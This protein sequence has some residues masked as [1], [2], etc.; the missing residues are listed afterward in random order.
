MAETM[1]K[2][3]RH[4]MIG[5]GLMMGMMPGAA[6]AQAVDVAPAQ[7][8]FDTPS[9]AADSLVIAIARQDAGALEAILGSA[10]R[11]L[12]PP[13][14]ISAKNKDHFFRAWSN[15][16]TLIPNGKA[17]RLLLV[18]ESAWTLP[19][20]IVRGAQG[21]YFDTATAGEWIRV[22][23]IGRNELA[24]MRAMLAYRDA[25]LEY[26][27]R[28][29]DGDGKLE[30]A[31]AFISSPGHRNG[32]YWETSSSEPNCPL[33]PRFAAKT[34]GAAYH[35]YYYRI[36]TAQGDHAPGGAHSY[37]EDG[38]MVSGFALI[39]WPADYGNS[40]IMSFMI[41]RDGRLYETDLGPDG[42]AIATALGAF[43]PG[44]RW[45]PVAQEY[46]R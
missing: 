2:A 5:S 6:V 42:E 17:S 11:R 34:P 25:Q 15:F 16:H 21:W 19:I 41:S 39:A 4:I 29:H 32:L 14:G 22:R 46:S 27:M 38:N 35:G 30:F 31:Q 36:L 13:Q 28:D 9:I 7:Q 24:A 26:G 1:A 45:S 40:G 8:H 37:L 43:D 23:R 33:G 44:Q 3:V 10:Y 12:L 20:P 18:G